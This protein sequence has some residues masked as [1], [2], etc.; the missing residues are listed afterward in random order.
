[1][2][3]R[4]GYASPD[5]ET[6]SRIDE[7]VAEKWERVKVIPSE[8]CDDA[9]FLRRVHLD[10]TGLPPTSDQVREFLKDE[11]ATRIK[12]SR[13]VD[14]LIGSEAYIDYWTNKWADLLQVNRKFLGVEGSTKFRDWIR[15][16]VAENRPY[17][18]FAREILTA[19]GSNNDNPPASYY[20]VLRT[21]EDTMENTTHLFLGIRFNCNKCHDHPFE[22]WTQDQYYEMAA[23][24]AQVGLEN[25]P[26]SG[27]RKVGGTA[28]E[29]AKPLFEK[30]VDKQQGDV[31]HPTTN[32]P[33]PPAFPF[34]VEHET[35]Q[36]PTRRE[37]LA[38]WITDADNPYF[39]RSYVNRLWGYLL[40]VG[41]IEPIDDIRAGNPATN[42]DL[43]DHLAECFVDSGFNVQQ[44]QREICNS[45]TY[46]L[47]VKTNPLN[48]DDSL[49]YSHALPRRLPAEVIYDT[50]HAVTGCD[51]RHSRRPHGNA[52]CRV[53]RFR[54]SSW[55][56]DSCRTWGDPPEK[57]PANASVPPSC[58]SV[59]S[60]H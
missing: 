51:Q 28:V 55:K 41:L 52:S 38:A 23:Y 32:Q 16:A 54:A 10:L 1:M 21:P 12:R 14:E 37:E 13:V 2:G 17:D 35:K 45:R 22:R 8:L 43:L 31:I 27:N 40:G 15:Q 58:N 6:W 48:E 47:S 46:Q 3:D 59:P 44:M 9:T 50:V 29:G 20:K 60:W 7:L 33:V 42:P 19:T 18:Q 56:T 26:A 25:D 36:D 24:F 39:A 4:E 34:A 57:A 5:I 30:V 11:T 53:D 49:N